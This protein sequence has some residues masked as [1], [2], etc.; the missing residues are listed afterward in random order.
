V[1]ESNTASTRIW[2]SLGFKRIGRV[3]ACGN[4]KSFDEPIDAIIYGRDLKAEGEDV[5]SEERFDKIRYYLRHSLYPQGADRS[6]KSRL[7]SAATHYRLIPA[8]NGVPEK[9]MLK[10]KEVIS[11]PQTQFD[12]AKQAHLLAHGGIN[13]TTAAISTKYHWIR[14][15]ETVSQVI[16]SCPKCKDT[17]KPPIIGADVIRR[18]GPRPKKKVPDLGTRESVDEQDSLV[19]PFGQLS[20]GVDSMGD[21]LLTSHRDEP[22]EDNEAH[23]NEYEDMAIDPQIMQ[24]IQAQLA[25]EYQSDQNDYTTFDAVTN[26]HFI[27]DD[28]ADSLIANLSQ[29]GRLTRNLANRGYVHSNG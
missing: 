7:R 14:I 8:D 28:H 4:L 17:N 10:K 12:I 25:S 15:K 27:T 16:K 29:T 19:D 11:E 24:Q 21:Q 13:K 5:A 3:P 26:D 9:L 6:E 20:Q 18:G 22:M 1:Y 2:D 23:M